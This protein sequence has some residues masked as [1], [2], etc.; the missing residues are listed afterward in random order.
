MKFQEFFKRHTLMA[1]EKRSGE[2]LMSVSDLQRLKLAD[3]ARVVFDDE[4]DILMAHLPVGGADVLATKNDLTLAKGELMNAVLRLENSFTKS[5]AA[6]VEKIAHLP[7]VVVGVLAGVVSAIAG[8][9][10]VVL[11]IMR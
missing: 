2:G 6:L 1:N 9:A 4:A 10:A 5:Q 7:Y 8:I 11:A 3:K